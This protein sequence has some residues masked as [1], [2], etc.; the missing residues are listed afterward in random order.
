MARILVVDDVPGMRALTAT[1]LRYAGHEADTAAGGR[2]ALEKVY[3]HPPDLLLLDL[4]MPDVD[5]FA[6]LEHL[7]RHCNG[8]P[9]VPVVIF[10]ANDDD[11]SRRRAM[12]LGAVGYVLKG[13]TDN[14]AILE[15]VLACASLH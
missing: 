13:D 10:S 5:G 14:D 4:S 8:S 6:V 2:Q 1:L 9:P 12:E 7:C 3:K 11:E 15:E